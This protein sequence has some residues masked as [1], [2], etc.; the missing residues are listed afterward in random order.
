MDRGGDCLCRGIGKESAP[1]LQKAVVRPDD[2]MGSRGAQTNDQ[3]RLDDGS[4]ASSQGL[5]AAISADD[6]F[7]WI[8][9]L[10]RS[11]NLKCFTAL[12]T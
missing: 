7:L 8:R 12:V 3:P 4:S 5:Q 1:L 10:P 2:G 6:G 11:T 9:R